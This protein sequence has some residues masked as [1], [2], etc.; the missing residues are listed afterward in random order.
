MGNQAARGKKRDRSTVKDQ[1]GFTLP[2]LIIVMVLTMLLSGLLF[3]FA[4]GYARYN[5]VAQSDSIAFVERLNASDFLRENLGLS[6]GL[7]SQNSISDSNANVPDTSSSSHW[8]LLHAIKGTFG[9]TTTVT[10]LLYFKKPSLNASNAM[11]YNGTLP[12]EDEFILYHD[13]PSKELRVRTLA[14]PN[15]PSN[16]VTTSCPPAVATSS[17]PKDKVLI[18]DIV[19]VALRYFS[20]S[21]NDITFNSIDEFGNIPCTAPG[22][23]YTGCEGADFPSVEVVE[24]TLNLSKRPLGVSADTTQSATII[25]VALRNH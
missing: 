16:R 23:D 21:G 1:R 12:Y 24:L 17:C 7:I 9:N 6:S 13:G 4:I 15:V 22:P 5:T 2:E 8:R 20:R 3:Q 10:P 14:N 11:V 19:S 25:R 18:N